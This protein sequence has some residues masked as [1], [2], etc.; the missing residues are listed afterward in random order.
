MRGRHPAPPWV[1]PPF[2]EA[3]TVANSFAGNLPEAIERAKLR[4]LTDRITEAFGRRPQ[5]YRA[6]RYGIRPEQRAAA[7]G[8]WLSPRRVGAGAVRLFA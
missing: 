2:D 4:V 3:L 5:V 7:G 6:G 1:N 8:C